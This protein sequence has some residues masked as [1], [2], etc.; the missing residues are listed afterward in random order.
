VWMWLADA[1][2]YVPESKTTAVWRCRAS[3]RAAVRPAGPP[4]IIRASTGGCVVSVMF[5]IFDSSDDVNLG[6]CSS[7]R[8]RIG[9]AADGSQR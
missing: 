9:S 6:T 8:L 7:T 1:L 3:V 5:L 2:R 4:P